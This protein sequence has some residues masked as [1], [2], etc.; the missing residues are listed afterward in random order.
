MYPLQCY[1]GHAMPISKGGKFEVWGVSAKVNDSTAASQLKLVDAD[2]FKCI[3]DD[4]IKRPVLVD[5]AGLANADGNI[6]I[7]FPAPLKVRNGVVTAK[8]TNLKGGSIQLF[9]R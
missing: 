9:V 3:A 5:V 1:A 2:D 6:G 4:G 7:L 8:A